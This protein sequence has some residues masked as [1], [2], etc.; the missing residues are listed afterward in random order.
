[1]KSSSNLTLKSAVIFIIA[2]IIIG[3]TIFNSRLLVAGPQIV[4]KSPQDGSSF[5]HQ[6]IEIRGETKNL[7]FI[8]LDDKPIFIDE[9]G[10]FREKLLLSPGLSIIKL[11]GKD[12]FERE[13]E[14]IMH[15]VYTG[16]NIEASPI[17]IE[18]TANSTEEIEE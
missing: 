11:Y 13:T 14:T 10:R 15:Y 17:I 12:R 2:I 6:L 7:S 1:M 16:Q 18:D 8:S 9:N 5:D 4:I 3:Y